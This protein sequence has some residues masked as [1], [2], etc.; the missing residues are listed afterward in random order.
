MSSTAQFADLDENVLVLCSYKN[1]VDLKASPTV[2]WYKNNKKLTGSTISDIKVDE[3]PDASSSY[4]ITRAAVA[5]NANYHCSVSY[6]SVLFNIMSTAL[7]FPQYVQSIDFIPPTFILSGRDLTL[8]CTAMGGPGIVKWVHASDQTAVDFTGSRFT[9]TA[10]AHSGFSIGSTLEI[11]NL[12]PE[13]SSDYQ[14]SVTFDTGDSL[15]STFDVA[16]LGKGNDSFSAA[17]QTGQKTHK[18]SQFYLHEF[19]N[20]SSQKFVKWGWSKILGYTYSL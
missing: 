5:D 13:D 11:T 4:N 6:N 1:P 2:Q 19:E 16:V 10:I 7:Q 12:V 14:C 3:S 15:N 8:T 17:H 18:S 9:E 20:F